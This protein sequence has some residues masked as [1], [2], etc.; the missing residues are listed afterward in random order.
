MAPEDAEKT[1]FRT[2][3]GNFHYVVMPFGLKNAGATYQ[4]AMTTIFHDMI[5][6]IVED[7]VN[8]LVVKSRQ[9]S[10]HVSHLKRVF[11][12]CRKYKLKMN[13]KKCTFAV[14]TGKFL[15]VINHQEGIYANEAKATAVR[16]MPS[17][18]SQDQLRSLIGKF[19]Y[20][21]RFVPGLVEFTNP[22]MKLL[23]KDVTFQWD[24]TVRKA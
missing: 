23:K 9:A 22:M 7:Y 10:D 21:R 11:D 19:S 24:L 6:D 17:P 20:L 3:F 18:T 5:H 8:D 14:S 1:A 2:L 15:G 13:P 16:Q 12:R 4:R